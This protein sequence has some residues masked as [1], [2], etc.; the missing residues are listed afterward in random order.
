MLS[1]VYDT[2]I[3]E[4]CKAEVHLPFVT[5]HELLRVTTVRHPLTWLTSYW[6]NVFPGKVSVPVVDRFADL[7]GQTF[8][9]FIGQYLHMMPGAV[10][11]MFFEYKADSY[12]KVEDLPMCFLE[13]LTSLR[14]PMVFRDKCLEIPRMNQSTRKKEKPTWIRS[15]AEA[16]MEVERSMLEHF[17]YC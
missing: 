1:A 7:P 14:V 10:G 4:G 12:L 11:D 3:A 16:V 15:H 13:L 5:P 9:E 6:R 2:C 8:D 17:Q